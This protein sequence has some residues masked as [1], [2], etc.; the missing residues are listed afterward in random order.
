MWRVIG[1]LLA[2]LVALS[3]IGFVIKALRFLLIVA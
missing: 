2:V 1:V 3:L